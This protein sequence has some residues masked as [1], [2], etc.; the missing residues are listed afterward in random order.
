[1]KNGAKR[2]MALRGGI[3]LVAAVATFAWTPPSLLGAEGTAPL[4][5]ADTILVPATPLESASVDFA[6]ALSD[7]S[8]DALAS[9][10]APSGIRLHL[11]GTAH[12]GLSSRQAAASLRDFLRGYDG[13]GAVVGRAAPVEGSPVG[14]YAE[15]LWSGRM[16]GTSQSVQHTLFVGFVRSSGTWQVDEVRLLR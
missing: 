3:C 6:R 5:F 11:G 10:L 7:P 9:L 13:G 4:L 16:P 14:G 8:G 1:M 15:V 2:D 12:T